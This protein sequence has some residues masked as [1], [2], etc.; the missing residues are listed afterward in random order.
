MIQDGKPFLE[1]VDSLEF[2]GASL[3]DVAVAA[4]GAAADLFVDGIAFPN[5]YAIGAPIY[6]ARYSALAF[7]VNESGGRLYPSDVKHIASGKSKGLAFPADA[8]DAKAIFLLQEAHAPT[9]GAASEQMSILIVAASQAPGDFMATPA[10]PALAAGRASGRSLVAAPPALPVGTAPGTTYA[11]L[12]TVQQIASGK[13]ILER[14]IG[15]WD[16]Y[17]EGWVAS[18]DLPEWPQAAF[19]PTATGALR[20]EVAFGAF[21][22]GAAAALGPKALEKAS[23]V[24]KSAVDL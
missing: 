12:S 21:P 3:T 1:M 20:W 5:K 17:G 18:F 6:D 13:N 4:P 9:T 16:L 23:H 11:A 8:G 7:V 15:Q 10:P 14:K 19:A 2:L 24:A 22:A